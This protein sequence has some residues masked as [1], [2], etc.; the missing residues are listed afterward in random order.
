MRQGGDAMRIGVFAYNFKHKKTQEGLLWLMLHGYKIECI[1]AADPVQLNFYQS[2]IRVSQ[3]DM[4]YMHPSE[5]AKKLEIP[6]HVKI[7]FLYKF[8]ALL[9]VMCDN[10]VWYFK[11]LRY[12]RGM[13]VFHVFLRHAY[14]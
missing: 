1:L 11:F 13:H 6:Y 3:K 12:F 8:L 9:A 5:I 2:K 4:E 7:V 14:F 10:V